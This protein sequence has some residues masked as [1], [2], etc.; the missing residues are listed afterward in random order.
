MTSITGGRDEMR[1]PAL[2]LGPPLALETGAQFKMGNALGQGC[3]LALTQLEKLRCSETL[4]FLHQSAP[5]GLSSFFFAA[6]SLRNFATSRLSA[7]EQKRL[8]AL[9]SCEDLVRFFRAGV[10][11]SA[12]SM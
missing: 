5:F 4:F 7:I 1:A 10:Q 12:A 11:F 9:E 3:G 8:A 2:V 6:Q